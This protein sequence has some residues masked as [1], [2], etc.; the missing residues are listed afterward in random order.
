MQD[1]ITNLGKVVGVPSSYQ[2]GYKMQEWLIR[3]SK[4]NAYDEL[5]QE[6]AQQLEFDIDQ[7]FREFKDC[8]G[9]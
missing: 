9:A 5:T 6:Q 3:L 1:V 4:M 8:M 7:A 2:G